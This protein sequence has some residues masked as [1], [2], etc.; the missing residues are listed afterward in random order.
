[1]NRI[2]FIN[3]GSKLLLKLDEKYNE[4]QLTR[5]HESSILDQREGVGFWNRI[6]A[7]K[8]MGLDE[9]TWGEEWG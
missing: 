7:W 2:R 4:R 1:M 6:Y 9:G 8:E 5:D 3:I